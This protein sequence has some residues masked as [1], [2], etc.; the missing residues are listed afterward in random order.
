[1]HISFIV[2]GR[3]SFTALLITS[4][5]SEVVTFL[6]RPAIFLPMKLH[7]SQDICC[8]QT[9]NIKCGLTIFGQCYNVL[10]NKG[11]YM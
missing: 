5:T 3:L 1:M 11:R 2:Y 4:F 9:T 6:K 10:N 7:I 8:V